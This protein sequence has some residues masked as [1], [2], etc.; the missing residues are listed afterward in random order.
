M[1]SQVDR[2]RR[3]ALLA[4][5]LGSLGSV[6]LMIAVGVR[7]PLLV[8]LLMTGW[9]LG[10][11]LVLGVAI[12]VATRWS[13]ATRTTLY[14]MTLGITLVSLAVYASVVL[15]PPTSKPAF[16]FVLTP[17]L[18]LLFAALVV[19]LAAARARRSAGP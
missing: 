5:L 17:P 2:L 12:G 15:R 3:V 19:A 4:V 13:A 7:P 6:G 11:F 8:L 9:V 16:C 10:P 1:A 14:W 18:T